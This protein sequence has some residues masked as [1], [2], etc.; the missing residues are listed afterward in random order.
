MSESELLGEACNCTY[1]KAWD[2][3]GSLWR[4]DNVL[5]FFEW[6]KWLKETWEDVED[7]LNSGQPWTAKIKSEWAGVK[8]PEVV[9]Q[10]DGR[11]TQKLQENYKNQTT[12]QCTRFVSKWCSN[13]LWLKVILILGHPPLFT[14]SLLNHLCHSK[15]HIWDI[16][17][18]PW[19]P[20]S[21]LRLSAH[22]FSSFSSNLW[23][24]YCSYC[25]LHQ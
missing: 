8:G 17:S 25:M 23:F 7:D 20:H 13:F 22:D 5:Y 15:A 4:G 1:W 16:V 19:T 10:D 14:W 18:P 11:E 2:A 12:L 21:I 24:T 9:P 3:K 6:H